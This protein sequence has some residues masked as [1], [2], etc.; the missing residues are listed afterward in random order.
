[1]KNSRGFSLLELLVAVG[2]FTVVCGAIFGLLSQVNVRSKVEGDFL[3]TFQDGRV[4]IDQMTRDIHSAGYPPAN[5]YTA[6]TASAHPELVAWP[7][8][9]SPSYPTTP[10]SVTLD[11]SGYVSGGT[12]TTPS[13]YDLILET[14]TDPQV[15]T[16]VQ[17]IRYTLTGTTLYRGVVTKTSGTD[18]AT[19]TSAAGVMTTY[20][21]NVMNNPGATTMTALRTQYPSLYPTTPSCATAPCPVPLFTFSIDAGQNSDP[22]NMRDVNITL[23]LRSANLDPQT[24]QYRMVSLTGLARR[25]NPRR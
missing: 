24:A 7:F 3:D 19:A 8:A 15:S 10:C 21:E 20:V 4:A 17:W 11:S 12:C 18:P 25:L 14:D 1:M 5:E 22:T 9:W 6:T 2:M 23:V 16:A 13:S